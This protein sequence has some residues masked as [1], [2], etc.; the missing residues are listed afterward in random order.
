[1]MQ[2]EIRQT[3]ISIHSHKQWNRCN[4]LRI[5]LSRNID[6]FIPSITIAR[7]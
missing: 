7:N 5:L 3:I 4:S 6:A 2:T 1:M